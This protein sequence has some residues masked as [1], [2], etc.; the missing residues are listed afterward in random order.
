MISKTNDV[1]QDFFVW[2]SKKVSS[3]KLTDL[4][5][6]YFSIEKYGKQINLIDDSLFNTLDKDKIKR[7]SLSI[8]DK[9]NLGEQRTALE[10]YYQYLVERFP[11]TTEIK[12]PSSN[13]LSKAEN[14]IQKR[15]NTTIESQ[16]K[17]SFDFYSINSLDTRSGIIPTAFAAENSALTK[18]G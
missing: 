4:F 9:K 12:E 1:R 18:A 10:Y 6:T 17:R 16:N 11:S 14:P 13:S 15:T 3:K 7:L 2:L 8:V 5:L